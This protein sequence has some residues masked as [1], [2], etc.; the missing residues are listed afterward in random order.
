MDFD[1]TDEQRLLQ[2]QVSRVIAHE[3]EEA[4]AALPLAHE[5]AKRKAPETRLDIAEEARSLLRVAAGRQP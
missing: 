4:S 2:E 3:Y 5:E 1:L